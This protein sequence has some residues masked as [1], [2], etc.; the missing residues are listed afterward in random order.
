MGGSDRYHEDRTF[1]PAVLQ[2][3][4]LSPGIYEGC[5]FEG[6]DLS[7]RSLQDFRFIDCAFSGCGL[8]NAGLTGSAWCGVSLED[9]QAMGLAFGD[10]RAT[11]FEVRFTGCRLDYASFLKS[12][13]RS[14]AFHR[15]SL[16]QADFT[17]ADLREASFSGSLL[18][19]TLFEEC[20]LERC[21]FREAIDFSIDPARNRM[22]GARFRPDG[23]E[24]LL[25]RHRLD[26][27]P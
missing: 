15:C 26:L 16:L 10:C 11:P 2:A 24:G 17:G 22:R 23:L 25:R 3:E 14:T 27:G 19:G 4:G 9:C 20:N 6:C 18:T 1:T 8:S 5:R 12:P 7:G 13:L 21:D